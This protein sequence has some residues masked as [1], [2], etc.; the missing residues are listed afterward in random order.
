MF[1]FHFSSITC[2]VIQ[3]MFSRC[4]H[5]CLSTVV[6]VATARFHEFVAQ[7][8]DEALFIIS[9]AFALKNHGAHRGLP[10]ASQ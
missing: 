3:L 8:V 2:N 9:T 6:V 7:A 5:A 1:P 10:L 4:D